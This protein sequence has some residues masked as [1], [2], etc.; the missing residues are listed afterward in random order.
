MER[1]RSQKESREI[2]GNGAG[3]R[4]G[5]KLSVSRTDRG[6]AEK[7]PG[8]DLPGVSYEGGSSQG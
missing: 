7:N 1:G 2:R 8:C 5:L 6:F 3:L 4:D